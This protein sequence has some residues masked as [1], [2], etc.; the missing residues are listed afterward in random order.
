MSTSLVFVRLFANAKGNSHLEQD[1]TL[2][3]ERTNFVPPAQS[4]VREMIGPKK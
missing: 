3:L 2:Q 4:S 1:L